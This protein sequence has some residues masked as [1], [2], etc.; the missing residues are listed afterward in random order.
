M[1]ALHEE[2]GR[3]GAVV[4]AQC[5]V[6]SVTGVSHLDGHVSV[7]LTHINFFINYVEQKM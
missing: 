7:P 4:P 1:K 2:G 3:D 6:R 5:L